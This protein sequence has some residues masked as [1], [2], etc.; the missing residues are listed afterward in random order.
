MLYQP[1]L[2]DS[3]YQV[4]E[5]IE[6]LRKQLRHG[7]GAPQR[8]HGLLRRVT[9]ARNIRASNSIEG[10]NVTID[11]AVAATENEEPLEAHESDWRAV[12]G[13]RRAM[14]YVLQLARDEHFRFSTDLI[15]GFHFMMLEYDLSKNPGQWRPGWVAV[16]DSQS[17]EVVYEGPDADAVPALMD[18][19]VE[20]LEK[21]DPKDPDL[22]QAAMAHLNLALIHPFSDGNGRMAR[23]LQTLVLARTGVLAPVFSSIEEYLGNRRNTQAYYDVLAEV[24]QGHWSPQSDTRL[25]IRFCLTAHFRQAVTLLM[26][27]RQYER[28]WDA[29]EVEVQRRGLAER[30]VLALWDA[31]IGLKVRNVTYRSAAEVSNDVASRDLKKLVDARLLIPHGRKRGRFYLGAPPVTTL[32]IR[33]KE[34]G[35]VPDPYD[36]T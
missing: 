25:W 19:L 28:L 3:D 17:G 32:F 34:D 23:C 4:I 14:T 26:R 33:F 11:D 16:R 27:L 35:N 13:Y 8:W 5:K 31:A 1:S 22:V 21:P 36:V 12:V 18:G 10:Y 2:Q 30:L 24:A 20:V 29:L 6:G 9:L 15:R 7:V